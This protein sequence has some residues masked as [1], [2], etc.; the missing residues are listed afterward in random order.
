MVSSLSNRGD[1]NGIPS[2]KQIEELRQKIDKLQSDYS[3]ATTTEE[4]HRN[5]M[6]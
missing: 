1:A 3:L 5:K 2:R 6:I 4:E